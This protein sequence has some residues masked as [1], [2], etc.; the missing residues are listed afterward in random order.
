[1]NKLMDKTTIRFYL[2]HFFFSLQFTH[3]LFLV[4][5]SNEFL[6]ELERSWMNHLKKLTHLM[7]VNSSHKYK[8]GKQQP[9]SFFVIRNSN[10]F[11]LLFL[12]LSF[13]FLRLLRVWHLTSWVKRM[14][15]NWKPWKPQPSSSLSLFELITRERKKFEG[16]KCDEKTRR[17]W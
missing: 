4:M 1:M 12:L 8:L 5:D 6:K 16:G 10:L 15:E 9:N 13:F 3:S 11:L 17:E 2:T 14:S 7:Y